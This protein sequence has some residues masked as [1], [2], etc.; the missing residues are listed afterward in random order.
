MKITGVEAIPFRVPLTGIVKFATGQLAAL[1]HVLVRISTAEGL[2]GIAEA[3]ARPMVYGESAK[4][5]VAAI[6]DWFAPAIVGLEHDALEEV[7][8]R[9]DRVE[10][11]LCAKASIDL[12]LHD[13]MAKAAGVPLYRLLGGYRDHVELCHILG[14]GEPERV[15][16]EAGAMIERHGFRWLKLKAGL[17]PDRDTRVIATV[18]AAVGSAVRLTVDCNHGYTA[19][20]A[21]RVL[22]RWR[23]FD[24]AWVEEPC[25]GSDRR[26]RARVAAAC[27]LPLMIDESAPTPRTVMDAIERG[28]CQVVSIKTARTG[29]TQSKKIMYLAEVNGLRVALGSQGDSEIGALAAAHFG[30]GHRAIAETCAEL[31]FFLEAA[32]R[33]IAQP[34]R[35][36]DGRLVLPEAAGT[37]VVLDERR[38]DR[39]RLDF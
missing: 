3:P 26:G 31:T 9:L 13:L 7:C 17:D 12:A 5:I 15:A 22:P 28:D 36:T 8:A 33:I 11:N 2:T 29:V 35:I 32:D 24:L 27:G 18:R 4:S 39:L 20:V 37:G 10:W 19:D 30:A 16:A 38:L 1:E 34:I 6:R 21:E 25:P 23:E 14:I